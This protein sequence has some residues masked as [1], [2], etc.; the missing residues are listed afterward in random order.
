MGSPLILLKFSSIKR[1]R[2][3][4]EIFLHQIIFVII[5]PLS[6]YF[7][8]LRCEGPTSEEEI[9]KKGGG[10]A[11]LCSLWEKTFEKISSKLQNNISPPRKKLLVTFSPKKKLEI[12]YFILEKVEITYLLGEKVEIGITPPGEKSWR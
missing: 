6:I 2:K 8:Q 3:N 1:R 7:L 10:K 11:N 5:L 9:K 12:I 4:L